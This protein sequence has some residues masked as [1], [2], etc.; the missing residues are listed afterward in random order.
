MA[1]SARLERGQE[2]AGAVRPLTAQFSLQMLS[3]VVGWEER[4][5]G[6]KTG[7]TRRVT[8]LLTI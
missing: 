7:R 8:G 1:E 2:V 6:R 4:V 5:M 3:S